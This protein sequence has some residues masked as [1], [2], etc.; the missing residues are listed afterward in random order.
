MKATS[1]RPTLKCCHCGQYFN[2]ADAEMCERCNRCEYCHN[3]RAADEGCYFQNC[4]TQTLK[5]P[6]CERCACSEISRWES[7]GKLIPTDND[8]FHWVHVDV[9]AVVMLD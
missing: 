5:C 9:A 8:R 2:H 3:A 7:E 1:L 6:H 4:G